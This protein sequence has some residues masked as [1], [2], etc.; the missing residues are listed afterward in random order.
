MKGEVK[1]LRLVE[2]T[3]HGEQLSGAADS[4]HWPRIKALEYSTS[5]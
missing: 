4:C 1:L 2:L 3:P 5:V